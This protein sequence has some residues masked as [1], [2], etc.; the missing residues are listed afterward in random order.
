MEKA[1][2]PVDSPG[3][4]SRIQSVF[5]YLFFF[6]LALAIALFLRLRFHVPLFTIRNHSFRPEI[7]PLL[8]LAVVVFALLVGIRALTASIWKRNG[9]LSYPEALALDLPTYAPLAFLLL[10]PLA[11]THYLTRVDLLERLGLF[12]IAVALAVLYLKV[13]RHTR[14]RPAEKSRMG[15]VVDRFLAWPLRRRIVVLALVSL[16][17]TNAGTLFI[18][19]QG[20]AFGGDEP[21]Y[22]LMSHSLLQDGD[23]DLAN[24]YRDSDYGAFMPPQVQFHPHAVPGKKE[25][26]LY[27]FHSPGI[28]FLL[29]PFYALGLALGKGALV[30]LVRFA[31]SLMGAI[32]GM[33]IYLYSRKAWERERLALGLWALVTFTTPVFFY[34]NHVY[35][36]IVV[37]ALGLLAFRRL[38]FVSVIRTR[39]LAWIGLLLAS[40]T[41]FHALKYFFIQ[42]PLFA[43]VAWTVF[44][45][46]DAQKR[47]RQWA[48]FLVPAGLC[49]ALYFYFQHSMYGSFNPTSV[50]WQGAMDGQQTLGFLKHIWSGI[51]FHFRW[52]TLAG[53]FLDQRDGL[54]LYA[55]IYAFAFLG[56]AAMWRA[57]CKDAAWLLAIAAPYILA[58]AFLTQRTGHAPQARPLV[59][60]I[61][62][63]AIFVG[64]FIAEKG[65][66]VYRLFFAGAIGFSLF[67]TWLLC[68]IPLALYQETTFGTTERAGSLFLTLSN[69]HLYLPNLLPSF[70]KI[71]AG[72]WPPNIIWIAALLLFVA[73]YL[74]IRG[75]DIRPSFPIH[76]LA[77]SLLLA[78]FF[79]MYVLFPRPVLV[80]PQAVDMPTGETWTFYSLSRVARMGEPAVFA[81]LQ[82]DRD[83]HFY[84]TT[85]N[86]LE[87]LEVLFGSLHGDYVLRLLT[88]DVQAFALK[89]RREVLRRTLEWPPAYRWKGLS[90][91]HVS[92]HLENKSD[93]RTAVTPYV[94]VLRPGR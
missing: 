51:P 29:L 57:K 26:S 16:F 75:R 79:V 73:V 66:H 54:L 12:A 62:V 88:A 74:L 22:L 85:Q 65:K 59:A 91:Y 86:P 3:R 48:S 42:A 23:L 52:E 45:K 92:L 35:P 31:M 8:L 15:Q 2:P 33:Q 77:V 72:R 41:W 53:Y 21:H 89:T 69:L 82:D 67:A 55:P 58:S 14:A 7:G 43:F 4:R 20:I 94:F 5:P 11:L 18:T 38:R 83:F 70:I 32:F 46:G 60:V 30:F 80:S 49:F 36:E 25:G 63:L 40:F 1:N 44:K 47:F 64:G 61:W 68:R 84:F 9:R 27:S 87:Q 90:L 93:V 13:I 78:V 34:S 56:A 50:S 28:A 10:A 6:V 19:S 39:D 24:N 81:L 17:L 37:A 71:E 76:L